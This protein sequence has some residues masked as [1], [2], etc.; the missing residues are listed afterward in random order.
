M[1][2]GQSKR[3]GFGHSPALI[4]V[5]MAASLTDSASPFYTES[6]T[7]C[8]QQVRRLLEVARSRDIPRVF[9]K[10]G[11]QFYTEKNLQMNPAV[12]GSWQFKNEEHHTV[13]DPSLWDLAPELEVQP[14]EIVITKTKP[15]AFFGTPL[16]SYLTYY[17]I[18]TA[19]V[20]GMMTGG[21][22]RCTV[23][24]AFQYNF[25]VIIPQEAVADRREKSHLH[26]L[27]DMDLRFG[28]VVKVE[29]VLNTLRTTV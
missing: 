1:V 8:L 20:A 17:Q 7:N 21:C 13:R 2:L 28:D 16:V 18:D 27:E 26:N 5:D 24:D 29:D 9:T 22:V 3:V 15:S 12:R 10:G 11:L 19:I 4:V 25:R 14:D 23:V 6:A